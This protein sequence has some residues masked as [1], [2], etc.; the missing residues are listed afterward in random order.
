MAASPFETIDEFNGV[1]EGPTEGAI[2]TFAHTPVLNTIALIASVALFIWFLT[3][4]YATH[5][6][7]PKIDKSLNSLSMLI[8]VG[9]LS[10]VSAEFR[11]PTRPIAPAEAQT[12]RMSSRTQTIPAMLL[13]LTGVGAARRS[14]P[15]RRQG[16]KTRRFR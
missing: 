6:N 15:R 10:L 5:H 11:Q 1:L 8:T 14:R 13:G 7:V 9:L 16:G 2:Y 12:Q 4:T 3:R